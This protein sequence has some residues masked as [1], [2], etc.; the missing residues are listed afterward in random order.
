MSI[1]SISLAAPRQWRSFPNPAPQPDPQ[2]A[3]A[4][5]QGLQKVDD[6][7]T[8]PVIRRHGLCIVGKEKARPQPDAV[9]HLTIPVTCTEVRFGALDGDP[10]FVAKDVCDALGLGSGNLSRDLDADEQGIIYLMTPWRKAGKQNH[11]QIRRLQ[12]ILR[13][14]K[15]KA[16][17]FKN[18]VIRDVLPEIGKDIDNILV[19]KITKDESNAQLGSIPSPP[20]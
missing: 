7:N 3:E 15:P 5:G 2:V 9:S 12:P 4:Q 20:Q 10:W 17:A 6:R 8:V 13:S 18:W 14:R 16:K 1:L 11:F 19:K